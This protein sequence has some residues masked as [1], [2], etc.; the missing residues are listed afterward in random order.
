MQANTYS[1]RLAAV[2]AAFED[3][4]IDGLLIESA[5][6]R[7]W[8]SG[9][10]GSSGRVLIT[11]EQALLATDFRY[12][13]QAAVQSPDFELFRERRT[14]GELL[15]FMETTAARR[16]GIEAGFTTLSRS[17]ALHALAEFSWLPLPQTMESFRRV[18]DADEL[19]AI[20]RAAALT[21]AAMAQ[22]NQLAEPGI[23]ERQ[24]A[25]ELEK[26]M[27]ESGADRLAFSTIVASGPNGASPHHATGAR[28]LEPG[29]AIT[30]DMGAEVNG[31][32]SDLTRSF[33]LGDT[34]TDRFWEIYRLT[35]SAHEAAFARAKA[36]MTAKEIDSLSRDVIAAA[37]YGEQFGH[38]LGHGVGLDIHEDP[39]LRQG[40]PAPSEIVRAGTVI[41]IEPGIYIPGWS[42]IRIEDLAYI[43]EEG[44]KSI[45]LCPKTPVIP[46]SQ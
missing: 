1:R 11:R 44:L 14:D 39:F 28:L 40:E 20:R 19:E 45:S 5:A 6:N 17:E 29:D 13:G 42:G 31:Y 18:K 23:S 41:T 37:G 8:L 36:G 32:K 21:D 22:V 15:R 10:T 46:L 16:I 35:L 27:R 30:V 26:R 33:F 4:G 43:T 34:P 9:F 3:W 7:R 24:L 2:R 38:G 12:W 25:W